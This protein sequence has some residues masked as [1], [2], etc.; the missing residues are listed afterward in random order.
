MRI[1]TNNINI[2][3]EGRIITFDIFQTT[4]ANIYA[5]SGTD[6][7]SRSHRERMFGEIFP[8]IL[9]NRKEHGILGGD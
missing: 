6:G 4:F 2:D 5:P 9:I 7:D 1:E 8:N 3:T